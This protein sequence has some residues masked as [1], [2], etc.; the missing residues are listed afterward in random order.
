AVF[1]DREELEQWLG[2]NRVKTTEDVENEAE[3]FKI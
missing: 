1:F 3:F 2:K